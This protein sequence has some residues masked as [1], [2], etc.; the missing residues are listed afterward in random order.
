[1]CTGMGYG[2]GDPLATAD[3]FLVFCPELLP[4]GSELILRFNILN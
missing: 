1:M 3:D 4:S 2:E